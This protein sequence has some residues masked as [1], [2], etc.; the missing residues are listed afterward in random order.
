MFKKAFLAMLVLE[1]LSLLSFF[2]PYLAKPLLALL[3]VLTLVLAWRKFEWG[4][5]ILFAELFVGSR[6]HLL[7]ASV[8]FVP[9]S[10][11][12]V[13][14][15]A[16]IVGAGRLVL[17]DRS[18]A[19]ATLKQLPISFWFL[20]L[21]VVAGIGIG[22]ASGHPT[23]SVFLDAN[24]YLFLA[25]IP[26]VLLAVK[27]RDGIMR[28]L[29]I[30]AAA[31][32]VIALQT[33]A[34]FVWF[35]FSLPGVA[36]LYAWILGQEIGEITGHVGEASRVFLQGQ[37]YALVAIFI[38]AFFRAKQTYYYLIF[39][40]AVFTV[41]MS[42]SRSFWLGAVAGVVFF[43]I[44]VL[45]WVRIR[46]REFLALAARVALLSLVAIAAA[47]LLLSSNASTAGQSLGGRVEDPT[48]G[49]AG[50]ARLLLL[51][52]LL[53]GIQSR[54]F[55]G[56]GFGKELSYASFLPDRVTAQ[57]PNGEIRSFAFEWGYLD[58]ALKLGLIGFLAYFWF[59]G[60]IFQLGL[61]APAGERLLAAGFLGGLA[62]IC[63]LNV[64]TPYLNHPLGIGYLALSIV[65]FKALRP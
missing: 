43:I 54:L 2:F 64:T 56:H 49:P 55:L 4:I 11:R 22:F 13:I 5:Y 53:D 51:P 26:L 39:G 10:L 37:F 27:D 59:L 17:A 32:L 42:L 41:L 21:A 63:V 19:W 7:E 58:L 40:A 46:F 25:V 34:A 8:G 50:E 33:L 9:V 1:G 36:P 48:Q 3:F 62:A 18:S 61:E 29:D 20:V 57:N 12:L 45:G 16:V 23:A 24:G 38:F 6:G 35:R 65:T 60:S 31:V 44:L 15:F 28:L 14:F 30:L 52:G 47:Y